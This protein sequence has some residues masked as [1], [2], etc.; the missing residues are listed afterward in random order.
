MIR[1]IKNW[2]KTTNTARELHSLDDRTLNDIGINRAS[3]NN[4]VKNMF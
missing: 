4:I 3:I 1:Q 2:I